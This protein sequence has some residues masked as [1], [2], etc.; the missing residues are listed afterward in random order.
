MSRTPSVRERVVQ[1]SPTPNTTGRLWHKLCDALVIIIFVVVVWCV[2][3]C[4]NCFVFVCVFVLLL[5]LLLCCCG[6]VSFCEIV[7]RVGISDE[8]RA[9]ALPNEGISKPQCRSQARKPWTRGIPAGT[10]Y[11]KVCCGG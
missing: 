9:G 3:F 10:H 4:F 5:V 2:L 6:C 1:R 8:G 7:L 11:A